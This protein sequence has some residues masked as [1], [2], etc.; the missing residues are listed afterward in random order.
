MKRPQYRTRCRY[1]VRCQSGLMG[2][3]SRLRVNYVD[4]AEWNSCSNLYDL[5][6]RLG[7]ADTAKAWRANPVIEGSV[8]PSDFRRVQ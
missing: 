8:D 2:W 5:A 4:F 7:F 3:R 6:G 1:R